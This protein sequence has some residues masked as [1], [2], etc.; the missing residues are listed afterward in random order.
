MKDDA[1]IHLAAMGINVARFHSFGPDGRKRFDLDGDGLDLCCIRSWLPDH[2]DGNP[3]LFGV[4]AMRAAD[5]ILRLCSAGYYVIANE[6]LP[7]DGFMASG[8]LLG[9]TC[10]WERNCTPRCVE[11]TPIHASRS[12]AIAEL[13]G[14]FNI[15]PRELDFNPKYRVEFSLYQYP[16]GYY[17]KRIVV[18]QADRQGV[19]NS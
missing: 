5:E 18:W 12:R 11:K 6:V 10:E 8:V 4:S 2:M 14:N 3:F 19:I 1:L 7:L 15:S 17:Q 16:V 9:D 13:C